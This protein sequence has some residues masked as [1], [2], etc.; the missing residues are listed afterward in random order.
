MSYATAIIMSKLN[1]SGLSIL[2]NNHSMILII[3]A[4]SVF[5]LD[6]TLISYLKTSVKLRSSLDPKYLDTKSINIRF[7]PLK[8][9]SNRGCFCK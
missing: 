4:S 1:V 5:A 6:R 3:L 7:P 8:K 9:Q 2:V